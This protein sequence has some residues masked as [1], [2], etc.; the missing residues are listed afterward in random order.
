MSLRGIAA[1]FA[2]AATLDEGFEESPIVFIIPMTMVVAVVIF[3]AMCY[4]TVYKL[5]NSLPQIQ[6]R[7]QSCSSLSEPSIQ[8]WVA[9]IQHWVAMAVARRATNTTWRTAYC[10]RPSGLW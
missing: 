5:K 2:V 3:I 9:S 1:G 4:F 8:H 7:I 6:A 10:T